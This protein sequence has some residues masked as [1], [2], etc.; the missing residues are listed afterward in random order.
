MICLILFFKEPVQQVAVAEELTYQ[1]NYDDPD[2]VALSTMFY[3][4]DMLT[5]NPGSFYEYMTP[6]LKDLSCNITNQDSLEQIIEMLFL[7]VWYEVSF[8]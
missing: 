2:A 5:K 7:K 1:E 3:T 8:Q 4:L 6:L